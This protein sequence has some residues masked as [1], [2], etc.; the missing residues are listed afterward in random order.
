M[1]RRQFLA[2]SGGVLFAGNIAANAT[3]TERDWWKDAIIYQIYPRS[4]KDSNGD[5]IGDLNGLTVSL[6]YVR[7][8]GVDVIW[9]NPIFASPNVDNGYDISDYQAIHS[10]FGTMSDFDRMLAEMRRVGLRLILDLV[11]NHCS[12]Q[13]P[14][15]VAARSSR[16]NPYRNYFHW[17]NAERGAPPARGGS[18][19]A[20]EGA[21]KFEAATNAFYLHY[22]APQQPDLNWENPAVRAEIYS[23][24]RFWLDKGVSGFRMDV[25][26]FIS[27]DVSFPVLPTDTNWGAYYASGPHLHEYLREMHDKVL[28]HYDIVTLGEGDG[29][30][31]DRIM[32]FIDPE[33]HELN[34]IYADGPDT[35]QLTNEFKAPDPRGVDVA[36][37]RAYYDRVDDLLGERGWPTILLGNH[38]TPRMVSFYGSAAPEHRD[39]ASMMLSTLMLTLRGTPSY[40]F[41][42]EL[43]MSN[44]R[45][46]HIEDYRDVETLAAYRDL[47]NSNG[48]IARFLENQKA[49]ARD[50]ART[51]FQW[52][53][54]PHA[55]FTIGSPW[56][57]IN[58]NHV[59]VNVASEE[60]DPNSP[61][62]YFRRLV[63]LRK[64]EVVL[65]R[66][67]YQSIDRTNPMAY[68]YLRRLAEC[69][70]LVMLNFKSTA[71]RV[72]VSEID[73]S[74]ARLVLSNYVD[75]ASLHAALRPYEAAVYRLK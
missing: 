28:A 23:I 64:R 29:V 30:A 44:I 15:F 45:F 37:I 25:I 42:D 53:A 69:V 9:L 21:W 57:A 66:G 34:L 47:V 33:R 38:D 68:S 41:G 20:G 12:D 6:P 14:W 54:K 32:D 19:N 18:F 72:D 70:F 2:G 48:N 59:T 65:R 11:P 46:E 74:R 13:H 43:G 61:L 24:M 27:K 36:V 8:L 31:P 4:F 3:S 49:M 56:L 1:N 40:Y 16:D 60:R 39:H 73:T 50:N 52:D 26:P 63:Q 58:S 67:N 55:G 71:V 10:D 62:N 17:L 22:F 5:G 7:S 51:P 35:G 75:R